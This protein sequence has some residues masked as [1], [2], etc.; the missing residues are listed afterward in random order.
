[1]RLYGCPDCG[2][3]LFFRNL[4][5]GG[6]GQEVS[7]DP[8]ADRMRIGLTPCSFRA[9]IGCNWRGEA[10]GPCRACA[11]N[12]EVPDPEHGETRTLWSE[13]ELA[14]RWVLA[15]LARWGWFSETD[16]GAR[17]SFRLC[18]EDTP[19][20]PQP[21]MMGHASGVI[22]IN[23]TESD[24]VE[25]VTRREALG[26]RLRT[27]T[28]HF[29]HEIA[30]FLFLRLSEQPGFLAGF[31][32]RFGDERADYSEALAR[33]Y[34]D[35]PPPDHGAHFITAYASAHPHED[36]AE[37]VAHILHLTDLLDS[38]LAAGL[39]GRGLPEPGYDAYAETDAAR[40][41][42]RSVRLAIALNHVTRSIG[43][44]D[45][46]PFVLSQPAREKLMAAHG[47]LAAGPGG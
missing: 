26:E 44:P 35:G 13:A 32:A 7:Y 14:K 29:R 34:E 19:E 47:W 27:M 37:T 3:P 25:R 5:C 2:A 6:C 46:Y 43:L 41:L 36:W 18:A 11:V 23:V 24:P 12:I 40:L 8:E 45:T 4:T 38:A 15:G 31:R 17:P 39:T 10:A 9:A 1:M 30:H 42:Q 28:D 33:F 21:V 16:P 20:G 22:T